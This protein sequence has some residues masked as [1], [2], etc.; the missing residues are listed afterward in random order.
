MTCHLMKPSQPP[1]GEVLGGI[2]SRW[3]RALS[4][5]GLSARF[6]DIVEDHGRGA[7]L[8]FLCVAMAFARRSYSRLYWGRSSKG[9]ATSCPRATVLSCTG[10]RVIDP[11]CPCAGKEWQVVENLTKLSTLKQSLLQYLFTLIMVS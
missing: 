1:L 3:Y 10:F 4:F 8:G 11:T 7:A 9:N 2:S 6:L 5:R